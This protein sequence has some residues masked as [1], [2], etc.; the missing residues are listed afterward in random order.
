MM[1]CGIT[2]S[3]PMAPA[4]AAAFPG[5]AWLYLLVNRG[6]IVYAGCTENIL[7]R[8]A[9]HNHHG[10]FDSVRVAAVSIADKLRCE[11]AVIADLR[12]PLNR[13]VGGRRLPDD[14]RKDANFV[15]KFTPP[16]MEMLRGLFGKGLTKWA[17][18]ELLR[19]S[20][21]LNRKKAESSNE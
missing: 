11:A 4:Q 8:M 14:V 10:R 21:R 17:R 18:G 3:E 5:E 16:Q 12:P 19:E 13:N 20:R 7:S 9:S 6:V 1:V 15:V 2:F